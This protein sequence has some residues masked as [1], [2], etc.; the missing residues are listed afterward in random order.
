MVRLAIHDWSDKVPSCQITVADFLV[1]HGVE[2]SEFVVLAVN[3]ERL[4]TGF[5]IHQ[6]RASLLLD[7]DITLIDR[8]FMLQLHRLVLRPR[9]QVVGVSAAPAWT[10]LHQIEL[11]FARMPRDSS[12]AS[13]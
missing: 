3:A 7:A 4:F 6:G 12:A 5:R 10:Y 1:V 2:P 11:V 8:P 13:R 9:L